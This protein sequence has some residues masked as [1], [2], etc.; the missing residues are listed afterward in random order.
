MMSRLDELN[1]EWG[2]EAAARGEVHQPVRIGIGINTGA[3]CVGN[4]GSP[5]RV[6][7]SILG[8]PVNTASRLEESTKTYGA[9][10]LC[11]GETARQ[12]TGFALLDIGTFALRGKDRAEHMFAVIGDEV[13]GSSAAFAELK[14]SH[15]VLAAALSAGDTKAAALALTSCRRLTST[16]RGW[17]SLERLWTS[18]AD[19][20]AAKSPGV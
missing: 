9:P 11:G 13:E 5:R 6:N 18:Y 7:Y 2:G 8:D 3:C 20:L 17:P 16:A 4:V 10:I 15:G 14:H 1:D 19:Q 12:A